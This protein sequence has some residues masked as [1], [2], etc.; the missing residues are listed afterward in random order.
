MVCV[1][2]C[3]LG[4]PEGNSGDVSSLLLL[5][6]YGLG[7]HRSLDQ[8][9]DFTGVDTRGKTISHDRSLTYL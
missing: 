2:F 7:P 8:L 5:T 4:Y 9:I 6:K 1:H 3:P